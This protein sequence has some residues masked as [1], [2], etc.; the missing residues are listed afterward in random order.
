LRPLRLV[1]FISGALFGGL[2]FAFLLY[3]QTLLED[4][5]QLPE[6]LA[7]LKGVEG[8]KLIGVGV[9]VSAALIGLPLM[10]WPIIGSVSVLLLL[11]GFLAYGLVLFTPLIWRR[12]HGAPLAALRESVK[13]VI[14]LE[15]KDMAKIMTISALICLGLLVF[16]FP[17]AFI[18][19]LTGFATSLLFERYFL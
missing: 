7:T 18:L 15:V 13:W 10:L 11:I 5:S 3:A 2:H 17:L 1:L 12:Q 19:P 6:L 14:S 9:A 16:V 8:Q 4:E